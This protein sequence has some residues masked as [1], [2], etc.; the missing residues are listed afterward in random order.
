MIVYLAAVVTYHPKMLTTIA[1]GPI[2][3]NLPDSTLG[4]GSPGLVVKY[5]TR[6]DVK[7]CGKHCSLLRCRTNY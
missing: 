5:W 2:S 6:V 1:Q 7:E 3:K 4:V